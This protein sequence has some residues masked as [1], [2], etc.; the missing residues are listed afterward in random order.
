MSAV[1]LTVPKLI[2]GVRCLPRPT[3][4]GSTCHWRQVIKASTVKL[5]SFALKHLESSL[6]FKILK[7]VLH[8]LPTYGQFDFPL[9]FSHTLPMPKTYS[10]SWCGLFL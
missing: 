10:E 4:P 5:D 1:Q 7:A 3:G 8:V 6:C 9:I 2:G